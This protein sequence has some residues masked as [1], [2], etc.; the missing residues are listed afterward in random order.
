MRRFTLVFCSKSVN[1]T[2]AAR[3]V[4]LPPDRS[5]EFSFASIAL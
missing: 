3:D 4:D 2:Q 1:K 5:P